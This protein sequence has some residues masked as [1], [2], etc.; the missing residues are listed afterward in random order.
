MIHFLSL[1]SGLFFC[2]QL[3]LWVRDFSYL[4]IHEEVSNQYE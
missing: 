1:G 2:F 3:Y 4:Q